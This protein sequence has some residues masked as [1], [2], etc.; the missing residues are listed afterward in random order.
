LT[1]KPRVLFVGRGRLE[2]PLPEWL[3]KKW[4]ALGEVFE[5]RVLNAGRGGGDPRFRLLS[6][7]A[8]R[9]YPR[10]PVETARELRSFRPDAVVAADPYVAAG[11][12]AGRALARSSAKVI[13]E[14]HGDPMTFTRLYGSGV[15][16]VL[17]PVADAVSVRSL[18]RADAT[19]AL[20][21]FTSS[22]VERARGRPATA[23]FPTY[24]D[25]EAFADPPLQ[26]V[27]HE[28]RV[29][30]IGALEPYKNVSGLGAAWR[31][32]AADRPDAQL[33]IVGNGSQLPVVQRLIAQLPE[34]VAHRPS[35]TPPEVVA[36]LDRA[37]ALVLPSWPEGLGR[38]VLEAFARGRGA[39]AT[40][41]G[42]IP[43]IVTDGRD[44]LLVP[45]G[46][47]YALVEALGRILDDHELAER[48][49]KAARESYARWHQTSE[50]F[51]QAYAELVARVLSGA[52]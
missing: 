9:F 13:V 7:G 27:P 51:A 40:N 52:R 47:T 50:D 23:C 2:L 28:Q 29:V 10:L 37:R 12:F 33:T 20:S 11:V 8:A 6:D 32:V 30:F 24:S 39:V 19:R 31:R 5:L 36:E 25:L 41:A 35:L 18:R 49:G 17:S 22:V 43:D 26:A 34:Q 15:R 16:R 48:L 1:A 14:V 45:T 46:D 4:D 21:G 38:V 42:G 44:G 3:Q